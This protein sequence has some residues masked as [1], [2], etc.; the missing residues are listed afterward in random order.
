L[1]LRVQG[2]GFRVWGSGFRVQG[3]GFR[4]QGSGVDR[5]VAVLP[6]TLLERGP[7]NPQEKTKSI[8]LTSQIHPARE[9]NSPLCNLRSP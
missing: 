5:V 2:S 9:A 1:G 4:V 7:F 3:S 6:D 8:N